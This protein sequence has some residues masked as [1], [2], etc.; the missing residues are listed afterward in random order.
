MKKYIYPV[1]Q[2]LSFL[3]REGILG[4]P[5]DGGLEKNVNNCVLVTFLASDGKWTECKRNCQY[6]FNA[7][8]IF[9]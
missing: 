5:D 8:L 7:K 6:I 2:E 3:H 9:F 4:N 1:Y